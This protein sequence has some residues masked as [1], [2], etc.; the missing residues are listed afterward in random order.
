[1]VVNRRSK[2]I[3]EFP[4]ALPRSRT[5]RGKRGRAADGA[6]D[7]KAW[8]N[9]K[10]KASA[11]DAK[12][13]VRRA[14]TVAA[15]PQLGDALAGGELNHSLRLVGGAPNFAQRE[16]LGAVRRVRCDK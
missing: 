8:L 15:L 4:R 9:T 16:E 11:A 13:R 7:T 5:P 1:M 3:R 6:A 14:K 12:K 2:A 10:T